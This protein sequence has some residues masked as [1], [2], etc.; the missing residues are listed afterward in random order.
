M[1]GS[2]GTSDDSAEMYW[3]SDHIVLKD[4][5]KAIGARIIW[6]YRLTFYTSLEHFIE[7]QYIGEDTADVVPEE[8][9]AMPGFPGTA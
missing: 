3:V 8:D 6:K 9:N 4:F 2:L 7:S 5:K 1:P